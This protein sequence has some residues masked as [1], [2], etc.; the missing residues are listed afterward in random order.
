MFQTFTKI[1]LEKLGW[2]QEANWLIWKAFAGIVLKSITSGIES[3]Q[4]EL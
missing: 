3:K 4:N 1:S 2:V